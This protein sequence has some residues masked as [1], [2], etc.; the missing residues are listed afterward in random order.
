MIDSMP[1]WKSLFEEAEKELQEIQGALP[2]P[3]KDEALKVPVILEKW[4]ADPLE[5]DMLGYYWGFEE[6]MVSGGCG[7]IFLFLGPIHEKCREDGTDFR[8]EIRTTYLHELG[9]HLG[10]DEG[11]LDQRGLG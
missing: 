11:D 2:D 9:H 6:G 7:P 10:W 3:V 5:W 4:P 8:Q 1:A